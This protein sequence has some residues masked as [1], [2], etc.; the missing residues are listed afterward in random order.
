MVR[1]AH[2]TA[3]RMK[4]GDCGLTAVIFYR[5][6]KPVRTLGWPRSCAAPEFAPER[7]PHKL[8]QANPQWTG[9]PASTRLVTMPSF[10]PLRIRRG[11][12]QPAEAGL[13][14]LRPRPFIVYGSSRSGETGG[15]L[16]VFPLS[17]GR[18]VRSSST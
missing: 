14:L 11:N 15:R 13:A 8:A 10:P 18:R 16:R 1:K 12:R 6:G 4:S 3:T 9:S 7:Q 17:E 5:E 2:F